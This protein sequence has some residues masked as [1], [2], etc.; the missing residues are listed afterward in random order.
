MGRAFAGL[1]RERI[2]VMTPPPSSCTERP[3]LLPRWK[4]LSLPFPDPSD[5][6]LTKIGE[7]EAAIP[8]LPTLHRLGQ[9]I[10]DPRILDSSRWSAVLEHELSAFIDAPADR[11]ANVL[12]KE[13][14]E[15][16]NYAIWKGG[17]SS[18]HVALPQ[19][20][21]ANA[22]ATSGVGTLRQDSAY[23]ISRDGK[24]HLPMVDWRE[25]RQRIMD[26]PD[27]LSSGVLGRGLLSAIRSLVLIN[28]AHAFTDGNG[29]LGRFLFNHCLHAAGMSGECYLPLKTVASMSKGGYEIR[30]RDAILNSRWDGLVAY[31]CGVIQFLS[32][33]SGRCDNSK[34]YV[35]GP[36]VQ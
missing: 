31:Y 22:V 35:T 27:L 17:I 15:A 21:E 30:L 25:S 32:E 5:A 28:N 24:I 9:W 29:R 1:E 10:G 20:I 2:G 19:I 13:L 4:L 11:P 12:T 3:T 14:I 18:G 8:K 36:Y 33:L 26:F 16:R 7:A 34:N 23:L 6:L